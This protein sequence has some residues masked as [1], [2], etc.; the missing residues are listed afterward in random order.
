MAEIVLFGEKW[1][2][3]QC[4]T[5][6]TTAHFVAKCHTINSLQKS[7]LAIALFKSLPKIHDHRWGSKQ[8]PISKL[9]DF[10]TLRC[11]RA[12]VLWPKGDKAHAELSLLYHSL[13]QSSCSAFR[14][15]WIPTQG[16]STSPLAAAYSGMPERG[17]MSGAGEL[18]PCRL[19]EG[20]RWHYITTSGNFRDPGER[21]NKGI[22]S[23]PL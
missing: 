12:P 9:K 22:L 14:H 13:H 20:H 23:L 5:N 2:D 7:H 6:F 1:L 11:V 17:S 19:K 4:C 10:K 21:W 8:R 18:P 3:I 15:P 16:T